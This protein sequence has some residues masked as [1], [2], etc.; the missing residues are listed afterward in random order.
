MVEI[1][2]SDRELRSRVLEAQYR[3]HRAVIVIV[4]ITAAVVFALLG[5]VLWELR[6]ASTS[7]QLIADC[8]SPKGSCAVRARESRVNFSAAIVVCSRRPGV[9]TKVEAIDCILK[10]S[11]QYPYKIGES[12]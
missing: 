2:F 9:N 7:R 5:V 6:A 4:L 11:K 1:P 10:E 8:V 12:R 3:Y